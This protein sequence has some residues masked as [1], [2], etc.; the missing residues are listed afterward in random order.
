[1]GRPSA[2]AHQLD[3]PT[4]TGDA[5]HWHGLRGYASDPPATGGS[6]RREER[7]FPVAPPTSQHQGGHAAI[8]R[9]Q[10]KA[11]GCRHRHSPDFPN[12]GGK[13]AMPQPFLHYRQHIFV[14]TTLGIDYPMWRKAGLMKGGREQIAARKCPEDRSARLALPSRNS[15]RKQGG[16]G[17]IAKRAACSASLMQRSRGQPP[18]RKALVHG[19]NAERQ[20]LDRFRAASRDG[21]DRGTQAFERC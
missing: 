6:R 16:G 4:R 5:A 19:G 7:I 1:M 15:S 3:P 2:L 21:A 11:A 8:F 17:I 13:T 9:G 14:A 12:H 10:L 18:A 20:T